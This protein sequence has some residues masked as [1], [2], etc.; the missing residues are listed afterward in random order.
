MRDVSYE[1]ASNCFLLPLQVAQHASWTLCCCLQSD[2]LY[3]LHHAARSPYSQPVTALD[4][5]TMTTEH[6]Y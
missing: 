5:V 4:N 6:R 3:D 1:L 2:A